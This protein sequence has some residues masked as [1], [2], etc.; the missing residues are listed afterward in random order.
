MAASSNDRSA[1]ASRDCTVTV[2]YAVQKAI[3]AMTIVVNP[4][5]GQENICNIETNSSSW[6]IPVMISGITSGALTMPVS[7]SLPGNLANR[8]GAIDARV[9]NRTAAVEEAT[10]ASNDNKAA[11][12]IWRLCMRATRHC[13][14]NPPQTL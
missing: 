7:S 9:P 13:V 5:C 12:R 4:R 3:C 11:S 10:A 14:E 8:T 6:V 1:L 2:T